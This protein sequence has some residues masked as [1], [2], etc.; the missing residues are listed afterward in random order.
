MKTPSTNKFRGYFDLR[1][2]YVA[3]FVMCTYTIYYS[4]GGLRRCMVVE[5]PTIKY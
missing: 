2:R 1:L 5:M 4:S 3:T